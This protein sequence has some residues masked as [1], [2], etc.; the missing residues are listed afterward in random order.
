MRK[1][2]I[3]LVL[4]AVPLFADSAKYIFRDGDVAYGHFDGNERAELGRHYAYFEREG[5][6]YV[7]HAPKVLGQ[8][9]KITAPQA[10][11]G[12]RQADLGREQAALGAKQ[13]ALGAEQAAIGMK[14]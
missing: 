11:L 12:R 6:G 2:P 9:R 5:V 10:E 1:L 7:I 13:A 4:L 8:L 14:Q 3:L